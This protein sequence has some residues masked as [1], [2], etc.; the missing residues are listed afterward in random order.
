M[1][2]HF[3]ILVKEKVEKGISLFM[4]KLLTGYSM[5]F[6][7]RNNRTGS[8][9]QG[10]SR[11]EHIKDDRHLRYLFSYIH[12]NPVK[13]FDSRWKEK[14]PLDIE[15]AKDFLLNF[16]HSSYLD[17]TNNDRMEKVILSK[18]AFPEYF[19]SKMEFDDFI[20]DWLSYAP[21]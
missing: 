20:S 4:Q 5:Y 11:A 8:L 17:Y 7:K 21:S 9:F 18:E 14:Y 6:N 2:N 13:L 19:L 3:H 15:K 10:K 16:R 1:P 12:L